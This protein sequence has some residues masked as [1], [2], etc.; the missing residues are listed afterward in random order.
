LQSTS[1]G[2]HLFHSARSETLRGYW[3]IVGRQRGIID[4]AK[5]VLPILTGGDTMTQEKREGSDPS[6]RFFSFLRIRAQH[7]EGVFAPEGICRLFFAL[8]ELK[9]SC[10]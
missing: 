6:R 7:N 1:E 10:A 9:N 5:G 8:R 2:D 3:P 4:A